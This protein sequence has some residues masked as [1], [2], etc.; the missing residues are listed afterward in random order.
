MSSKYPPVHTSKFVGLERNDAHVGDPE[1]RR[2][3]KLVATGHVDDY[4]VKAP[5]E[6]ERRA[7]D[8]PV[9]LLDGLGR[10]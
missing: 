5:G 3:R 2:Y 10:G 4:V 7:S 9:E 6:V 8:A 1:T